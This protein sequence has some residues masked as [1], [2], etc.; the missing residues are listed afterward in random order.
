MSDTSMIFNLLGRDGVSRALAKIRAEVIRTAAS[1]ERIGKSDGFQ[2]LNKGVDATAAGMLRLGKAAY[3]IVTS[4]SA[5]HSA[6]SV[7]AALSGTLG[8][9][10]AAAV[11]GGVGLSALKIGVSGFGAALRDSGNPKKY[12]ADLKTLAPAARDTAVEIKA[13]HPQ[14]DALKKDVQGRLFSGFAGQVKGLAAKYLPSLRTNLSGVAGGFNAAARST[15]SYLSKA[16]QVRLVAVLL[17]QSRAAAGNLAA[18]LQPAVSILLNMAS[19]GG[20]FLPRLTAGIGRAATGFANFVARARQTGQLHNWIQTGVSSFGQ[21]ITVLH[22]VASV[23]I[24]VFGA[25]SGGGAGTLPMLVRLTAQVKAFLASAQGQKALTALTGALG[26]VASVVSQVLLVALHQAAPIIIALA[27]VFAQLAQQVGGALVQALTVAGPLLLSLAGWL[28]QNAHWLGPLAIALAGGVKAFRLL[29][30]AARTTKTVVKGLKDVKDAADLL[31]K[32]IGKI[33]SFV[34]RSVG[35]LGR[36]GGSAAATGGRLAASA[37]R[38]VAAWVVAGARTGAALAVTTGQFIAQG[39]RMVATATVT[40]ARVVAGWVLMGV[41]SLIQAGRM[42]VAWV[43]AMGPIA[44]VIAAVIGLVALIITHWTQVKTI[45]V[46][47]WNAVTGW[48]VARATQ[49]GLWVGARIHDVLAFFGALASLPGKVA[50]WFGGVL[51]GAVSKLGGLVHWVAGLPGRILHSLGDLG[52]LLVHAG[53]SI[54]QGLWHGIEGLAGWLAGKVMGWITSV[55]PGP[56]AAALGI[57]SPSR[58]AADL[59]AQVPRGVGVGLDRTSGVAV[60]ATRRLVGR[61]RDGLGDMVMAGQVGAGGVTAGG[62]G[63]ARGGSG[64]GATLKVL[65]GADQ[66]VATM[67]MNLV[68]TNKLQLVIA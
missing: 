28:A 45:T 63:R 2:S 42:A 9:I 41:Q 39:A 49:I 53:A 10:P 17:G 35:A 29:V 22:N 25:F 66:A 32:G 43:I 30:G 4:M 46:A 27:P 51:T 58:V 33:G 57:H 68:R 3:T 8:L 55:I 40:A 50:G 23:V 6:I 19:A 11:A 15:G 26:T 21:L 36:L 59:A 61:V 65:P 12:A 52:S 7:A 14:L 60:A 24:S 16:S 44:L 13:L 37:A 62:A 67:I 47:V 1:V 64:A 56:I 18:A 38:T 5:A 31:G 54:V 20:S 48:I 34:G